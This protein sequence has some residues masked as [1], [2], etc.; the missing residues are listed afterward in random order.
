MARGSISVYSPL[1]TGGSHR[2]SSSRDDRTT[3]GMKR[4]QRNGLLAGILLFLVFY[5]GRSTSDYSIST[6]GIVPAGDNVPGTAA[7]YAVAPP[8]PTDTSASPPAGLSDRPKGAS[9]LKS[10]GLKKPTG[11][12]VLPAG[13]KEFSYALMV[14]AGSTGSRM[15]VYKFS[16]CLPEAVSA[17]S[18]EAP[19]PVLVD[20]KF[21]PITPGLSSYK[22]N[23]QAAAKSL[24]KL[25]ENAVENVPKSEHSCTPIAV[26]ATAGLR[27]LGTQQSDDIL[28]AVESWLR[29]EWPFYV[30]DNGVVIMDGK[31]E[32]VYA[33]ITINYV[34]SLAPSAF[35]VL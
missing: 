8:K 12:C 10:P 24:Q 28:K 14:D 16:N 19:L 23:P 17:S 25:M 7:D 3:F 13:K 20:E 21:Y 6:S 1:P 30:V 5:V 33:W 9:Q 4:W 26:K 34:C 27:L 22:G 15:H 29:K 11:K 2:R 35:I 32:G 18:S 31:D